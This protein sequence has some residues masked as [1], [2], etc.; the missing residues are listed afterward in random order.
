M[1][2]SEFEEVILVVAIDDWE[3]AVDQATGRQ[4][5]VNGVTR[6]SSWKEP[7][8]GCTAAFLEAAGISRTQASVREGLERRR[9]LTATTS[10]F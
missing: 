4:Y 3:V 2:L 5:Y 1:S 7:S 8:N 6:E 10:V 9:R